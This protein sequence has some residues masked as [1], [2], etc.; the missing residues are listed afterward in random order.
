[1]L[2]R[3]ASIII[4]IGLCASQM[5][6]ADEGMWLPM[7]IKRLN[8]TDMQKAGLKLT[9]EEIY[10]INN[11]SLKDAI[12]S[13]GG[14]CTGEMVSEQGLL[15]TNH[16]CGFDYVQ[17]HST[18]A[19]DY[20][21]NGFWAMNKSEELTNPGLTASFLI[22][23]D[24]VTTRIK[25]MM[26]DTMSEP[27]RMEVFAKA[28][29]QLQEENSEKGRYR[30]DVKSFLQGN[31]FYMFVYEV[32]KDVRLV[33]APPKAIGNYGA[34]TDNWMWP[35]HTGDFSV[36]RVYMSPD[37]KPA[38]YSKDNIPFKPKH[39]LPVS[40][41]GVNKDDFTMILGY[42]GRTDRYRAS[43]GVRM[44][45]E[46]S[47]PATVKI[48]TLKLDLMKKE[49]EAVDT[50][51]IMYASKYARVSNYWKYFIGATK[52]LKRMHVVDQKEAQEKDFNTWA[53]TTTELKQHYGNVT[54]NLTNAYSE[55]MKFNIAKVYFQ[56]AVMGTEILPYAYSFSGLAKI[57]EN[58]DAKEE[59]IKKAVIPL[60][61]ASEDYFSEYSVNTD[62]KI[63]AGLL[64]MYNKD[65]SV[66]QQ[67]PYFI[68]IVSKYDGDMNKVADNIFKHSL[69]TNETFVK[70]FLEKPSLK[71][72]KRDPAYALISEIY[73]HY[74]ATIRGNIRTQQNIID[75]NMRFYVEGLRLMS[76]DKKFYPDANGTMRVSYGKVEDYYPSD[77]VYYNYYTTMDGLMDKM[78]KSNDE[79]NLSDRMVDLYKKK[80]YGNYGQNGVLKIDF[81]TTNDITGGNSGSP[82]INGKG[83]LIGLAFDGNW[84]AMSGDISYDP[85]YKRTICADVRYVLWVID[86][87]AGAG[88]LLN[89]LKI[90][91]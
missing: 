3:I 22:R 23:M 69:F 65:V 71:E 34:D 75:K 44:D 31:E 54:S 60:L 17:N 86:K 16:H 5:S 19:H 53:N 30:V 84:E 27:T 29:K 7:L 82:V 67:A 78:D 32:F 36:F 91:H 8:E 42:P 24:D 70:K 37:G 50:V 85:N 13:F 56:E 43:N 4:L 68:K 88:Y 25:S 40:L 57:L 64:D 35:R 41:A 21:T 77:A 26:I 66:S 87:Y 45:I 20:I 73:T 28:T 72:L 55:M 46:Q 52:G 15:F 83:E 61:K 47:N 76:P 51:R 79:F 49:M 62:K 9:A 18:E 10:S 80:D 2:K 39:F 81:I 48:R 33:G 58:K 11:S 89:E 74:I 63:V 14:F 90:M 12:V 38:E 6:L 1:M 59:D